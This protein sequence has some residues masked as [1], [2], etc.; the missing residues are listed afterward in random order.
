MLTARWEA[1]SIGAL[2]SAS[3]MHIAD[4]IRHYRSHTSWMPP[5][6][7]YERASKARRHRPPPVAR[8]RRSFAPTLGAREYA[9]AFSSDRA[10]K[11]R[12]VYERVICR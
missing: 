8:R 7:N 6:L 4:P 10:A 1:W 9:A 11:E 5:G 3:A 2:R 12:A